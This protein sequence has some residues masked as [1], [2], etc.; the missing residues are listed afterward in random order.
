MAPKEAFEKEPP[1]PTSNLFEVGMKIEA[2]DK[3]NPHLICAATIGAIKEDMVHVAFDGWKG[4]FDYW[5]R[6]DSRDIFP[7]DWCRKSGHMLQ[8]PGKKCELQR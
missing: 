5:C 7:V 1:T 2:V 3:K 6:Y 8:P 4:A